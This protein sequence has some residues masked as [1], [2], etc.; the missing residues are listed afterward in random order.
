VI[1]RNASFVSPVSLD[2]Q[3][4]MQ[5]LNLKGNYSIVY[6]VVDTKIFYPD[7]NRNNE[8]IKFLHISTLDD[9]HKNIT[10]M[11]EAIARISQRR[12]DLQFLFAGDGDIK[13]HIE[14]AKRLNIYNTAAF[15][16][17]CKTTSEI[18]DLMRGSDCFMMFSNYENLPVVIIE[19]LA[20]GLPVI[21]SD[22]G[23]IHEHI[24][25]KKGILVHP[26]DITGLETAIEE[27][28]LK[29]KSDYFDK[30][31]LHTYANENFSY[32]MVSE[33]FHQLYQMALK[34]NV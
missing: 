11:L 7:N 29:L 13:P 18:A 27:M 5:Q 14:T 2:L 24:D 25:Q 32:E 20:S 21:S 6:N 9:A 12:N 23:G 33:K 26:N 22:V 31:S 17:G 16:E 8:K 19:A 10:G 34:E 1:T 4:A 28:S 15:F 3:S 30:R